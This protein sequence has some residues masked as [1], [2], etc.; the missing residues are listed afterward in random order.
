MWKRLRCPAYLRSREQ[1]FIR[2]LRYLSAYYTK[3]RMLSHWDRSPRVSKSS[4]GVSQLSR[5][6]SG[7][8]NNTLVLVEY[9]HISRKPTYHNQSLEYNSLNVFNVIFC[10]QCMELTFGKFSR[11]NPVPFRTEYSKW[12]TVGRISVGFLDNFEVTLGLSGIY[13]VIY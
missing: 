2:T 8:I 7:I 3:N 11:L 5:P 6:Q 1:P 13:V 9:A 12:R 10:F 4:S